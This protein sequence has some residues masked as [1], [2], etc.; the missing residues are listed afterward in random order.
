[1]ITRDDYE[2]FISDE[3]LDVITKQSSAIRKKAEKSAIRKVKLLLSR[4]YDTDTI[5]AQV[6]N[7]RHDTIVEWTIYLTLYILYQRSSKDKVPDDRYEQ[8]KEAMEGLKKIAKDKINTEGLPLKLD[9]ETGQ[10]IGDSV[11]TGNVQE[12]TDDYY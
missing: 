12:R 1:M 8:Y 7:N 9:P 10:T 2:Q 4:Q 5:F 6:G 11:I 3:E